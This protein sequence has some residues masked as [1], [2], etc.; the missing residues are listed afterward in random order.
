V[1]AEEA[2]LDPTEPLAGSA[3][4]PR[5]LALYGVGRQ[6]LEAR[7]TRD[8]LAAVVGALVRELV[9][10]SVAVLAFDAAGSPRAVAGH[11]VDL[12]GS[13]QTW[14]ISRTVVERVRGEARAVLAVETHSDPALRDAG[15]VQRYR[16]RSVICI[17]IGSAAVRGLVYLDRRLERRPF[18]RADL[19]FAT[20]VS[21]YAAAALERAAEGERARSALELSDARAA[22]LQEE[23][24]RH[25]I[26]GRAPALLSA[27][28][29]LRRFAAAGAR[30]LLRGET[31]TGKELFARAYA[32]A[33]PRAGG[34]FIPVPI[35]ALAP[36]LVESELFGHVRG[37]FTQASQDK[38]GRLELAQRGVLFLDEIGDVEPQIQ[39]KLLRFLDR[40]ELVRVGDTATRQVD[41]LIVSATNRELEQDVRAGRLRDDLLA[42]LGH[43]VRIPP[44]RERR[45]DVPLLAEHFLRR[46]DRTERRRFT[47]EA[48]EA[49]AG[50]DWPLNVRELQLVVERSVCL[51]DRDAIGVDDLPELL[52]GSAARPRA[53]A[54]GRPRTLRQVVDEAERRHFEEVLAFTGGNKSRAIEIL[55]ISQ[56]TFYRRLDEFGLR[57]REP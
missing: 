2:S 16:I 54:S 17:P 48:L 38:R 37:A 5:L 8:V 19:E 57:R 23:L 52:R 26:V 24:T 3:V 42:R 11:G 28:D 9:P 20:A 46:Y 55:G 6:L 13:P 34:P 4:D 45:E 10:D 36:G 33:C 47:A 27:Y 7:E 32:A 30:V 53:A 1:D 18:V 22:A 15:S 40:G 50:Y 39:P 44:L 49:L 31:G 56:D 43:V 51:V 12:S 41:A 21:L 14:P 35:P 25:E 29:A